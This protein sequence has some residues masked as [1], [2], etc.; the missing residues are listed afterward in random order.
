MAQAPTVLSL[1]T[2]E[3]LKRMV[4][5]IYHEAVTNAPQWNASFC[6]P[7]GFI[8]WWSQPSQAGNFQLSMTT[9]QMQ[10]VS[11]IADNFLR[12][13]MIN[14]DKHV[15]KVLQW[16]GETIGFWDGETLITWT[17]NIQSWT[18]THSMF[19]TSDKLET[20]ERWRPAKDASGNFIVP[21]SISP[22]INTPENEG[23]CSVSA[24]GR[25]IIFTSCR[26]RAGFGNCDLFESRKTGEVWSEPVNLGAGVNSSAWE[27]QPSLSADGRLLYFVSDRKGGMGS[28]DLYRSE[29]G[30]DGRWKPAVN[31]GPSVN[32]RYEEISPFI[33]ANGQTL[34]FATNGRPG[35]GGYDIFYSVRGDS[36]WQSPVNF[37]AP[38]NNHEDQFSL[39]I[40]ADGRR[41]YYSH[42]E[43]NDQHSGKIFLF[44]VPASLNFGETSSSVRGVVSDKVSGRPVKARVELVELSTGNVVSLTASDSQIGRAHV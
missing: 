29:K 21:V 8:R 4:Q 16:Y 43:E 12:Q 33:H 42:E 36:T 26:G 37:G 3:Y 10:T 24:D 34:F 1:L 13:V 28:R 35:F 15:Q 11:G 23:T 41:G 39:F 7:E 6:Y 22:A 20:V 9:W 27:S 30:E 40:T 38:V 19:E 18:L 5:L 32:T 31:L 2:P 17:A 44:D 25:Q 14:Q